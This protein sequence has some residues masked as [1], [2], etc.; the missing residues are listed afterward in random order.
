[1]SAFFTNPDFRLYF[2]LIGFGGVF[3]LI[4]IRR[5][6]LPW[7]GQR[8]K[9]TEEELHDIAADYIREKATD[10]QRKYEAY[11][12][13]KIELLIEFANIH[14]QTHRLK[15]IRQLKQYLNGKFEEE[16]ETLFG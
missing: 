8:V 3:L 14:I 11:D 4:I 1:M 9:L 2:L 6:L 13:V 5:R 7:W 16:V 10:Y 12:E 15:N